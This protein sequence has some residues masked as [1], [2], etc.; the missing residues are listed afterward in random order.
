MGVILKK[1]NGTFTKQLKKAQKSGIEKIKEWHK[2]MKRENPKEYHL[3][4]YEKFKKIYGY[5][6]TTV[7]GE[8]VRNKFEKDVAD[9]LTELN[10]HPSKTG[11]IQ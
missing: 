2:K 1:E 11:G 6:F 5:K 9:K 3:I 4:Q 7:K 10:N 8:K